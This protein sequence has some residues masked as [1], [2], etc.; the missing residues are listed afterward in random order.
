MIPAVYLYHDGEAW[1]DAGD[2]SLALTPKFAT[3]TRTR[4]PESY[5]PGAIDRANKIKMIRE[6]WD[7]GKR[8]VWPSMAGIPLVFLAAGAKDWK[9]PEDMITQADIRAMF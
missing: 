1:M 8:R 4:K 2:Y 6:N 5:L 7:A 3:L 9:P